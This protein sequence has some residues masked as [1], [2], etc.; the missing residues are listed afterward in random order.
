MKPVFQTKFSNPTLTSTGDAN[1][2]MAV[3]ASILHRPLESI[4][5]FGM[6]GIGWFE[7][8]HSWC[9]NEDIGILHFS[10][11]NLRNHGVC[12]GAYCMLVYSVKGWDVLH[13]VVGKTTLLKVEECPNPDEIKWHWRVEV[14]HDPNP[15]GVELDDLKYFVFFI[16]TPKE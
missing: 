9:M 16:P 1:C 15:H 13:A 3:V 2:L 8:L 5:D 12:M 14:V 6:S 11:E 7:E 10:E 4:P